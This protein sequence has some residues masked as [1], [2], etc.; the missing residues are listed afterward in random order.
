MSR[1]PRRRQ[2]WSSFACLRE[3]TGFKRINMVR[4]RCA[5]PGLG[6]WVIN[7]PS[8]KKSTTKMIEQK[9]QQERKNNLN[10]KKKKKKNTRRKVDRAQNQYEVCAFR[11]TRTASVAHQDLGRG[12]CCSHIPVRRREGDAGE[13]EKGLKRQKIFR[14]RCDPSR[15]P[16]RCHLACCR[17]R[18]HHLVARRWLPGRG[19]WYA[20]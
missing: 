6:R 2:S 7:R 15:F 16:S 20:A 19:G 1:Q 12:H 17:R 8:V 14:R 9:P 3:E 4:R 10:Q 18:C 13:G 11:V 5:R